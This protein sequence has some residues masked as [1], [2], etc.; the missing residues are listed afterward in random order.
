VGY[1]VAGAVTALIFGWLTMAYFRV[2]W[3][4]WEVLA[5]QSPRPWVRRALRRKW[6]RVPL[7]V[8]MEAL[9]LG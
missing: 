5:E 3:D 1:I 9:G 6:T 4:Q 2:Q 7:I 8:V